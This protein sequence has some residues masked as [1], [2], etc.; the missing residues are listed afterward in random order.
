MDGRRS[1]RLELRRRCHVDA[2]HDTAVV[3]RDQL[4]VIGGGGFAR[5]LR[6]VWCSNDGNAWTMLTQNAAWSP[7]VY[8]GVA[9]FDDKLWVFGGSAPDRTGDASWLNDVWSSSDGATWSRETTA[10][11]WSP[12]AAQ[13]SVVFRDRLWIYGGKGIEANG[14]GGF[15]DD[16]WA[17]TAPSSSRNAI[18]Q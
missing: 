11:P 13:Y 16:V 10:A 2:N 15:A 5:P 17:M 7:R 6:D 3:W 18:Q 12:R 14:R 8:P 9:V 1:R 4:C